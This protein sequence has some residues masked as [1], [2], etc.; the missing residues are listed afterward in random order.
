MP[1]TNKI[2][3]RSTGFMDKPRPQRNAARREARRIVLPGYPK[4]GRFNTKRQVGEYFSSEN[5]ECL[6]CGRSYKH[7]G[8]HIVKLHE[9]GVREYKKKYGLP[10]TRGLVCEQTH[11]NY[12]NHTY[13]RINEGWVPAGDIA[14]K[15][16][17]RK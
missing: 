17:K 2:G 15:S 16:R 14:M 13:K 8:Q 11:T 3:L 10:L 1:F 7:L 12:S 9:I 6:L 5:L 4:E